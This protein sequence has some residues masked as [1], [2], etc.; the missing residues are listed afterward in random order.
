M[1]F[2][3]TTAESARPAMFLMMAAALVVASYLGRRAK[4]A[5]A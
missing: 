5:Y 4:L 2:L 1:D 3:G